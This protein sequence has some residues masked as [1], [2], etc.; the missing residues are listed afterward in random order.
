MSQTYGDDSQIDPANPV[1]AGDLAS[2]IVPTGHLQIDEALGRLDG[3]SAREITSHP[4]EFDAIHRVL[5]ESLA[6]AGRD[7]GVAESP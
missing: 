3:I 7:E 5:R 4:E 2:A 6:D 1:A